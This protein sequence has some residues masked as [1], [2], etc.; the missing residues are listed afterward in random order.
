[1]WPRVRIPRY[2]K[3]LW[4]WGDQHPQDQAA[5]RERE[6]VGKHIVPESLATEPTVPGTCTSFQSRWLQSLLYPVRTLAREPHI[7]AA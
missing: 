6:E 2:K 5:R 1:V 7:G 3:T 4:A